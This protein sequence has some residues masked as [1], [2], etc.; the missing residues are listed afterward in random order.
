MSRDPH[1][2][3][4]GLKTP[5][6]CGCGVHALSRRNVV[7]ASL[8]IAS[9]PLLRYMPAHAAVDDVSEVAP[10]VFVHQGRYELQSEANGG[11]IANASFVVGSEGVAVIDTLGSAK[12]GAELRDA[13]NQNC[14]I[15]LDRNQPIDFELGL[16]QLNDAVQTVLDMPPA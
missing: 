10:G 9:A 5:H 2:P 1:T 11:D 4:I 7:L 16:Q 6:S 13:F 8:A 12:L 15:L 14:Q 3:S